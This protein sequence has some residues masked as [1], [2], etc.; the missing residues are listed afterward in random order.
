MTIDHEPTAPDSGGDRRNDDERRW[1]AIQATTDPRERAVALGADFDQLTRAAVPLFTLRMVTTAIVTLVVG[2]VTLFW[3]LPALHVILGALVPL[4]GFFVQAVILQGGA[5]LRPGS[6]VSASLA[7]ALSAAASMAIIVSALVMTESHPAVVVGLI[8]G[9]FWSAVVPWGI[10]S[11]AIRELR[12]SAPRPTLLALAHTPH[13]GWAPDGRVGPLILIGF[14][15]LVGGIVETVA[16]VVALQVVVLLFLATM[17]HGVLI[18]Q[19]S[20]SPRRI[21]VL[22][23]SAILVTVAIAAVAV[24]VH[25]LAAGA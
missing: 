7:G 2:A 21:A 23:V 25:H 8:G 17:A 1:D 24:A 15:N 12:R 3:A 10:P 11:V 18:A 22:Q 20:E 19:N 13:W 9:S 16:L 5:R 14:L 6:V 4:L